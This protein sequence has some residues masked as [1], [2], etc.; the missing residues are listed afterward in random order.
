VTYLSW[1]RNV[2]PQGGAPHLQ[3]VHEQLS[4]R[5]PALH[6]QPVYAPTTDRYIST[7]TFKLYAQMK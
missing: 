7:F 6:E 2:L 3:L 1:K 4:A 5:F